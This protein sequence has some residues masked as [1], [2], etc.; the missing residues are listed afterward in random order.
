[1]K[2]V[3]TRMIEEA[4]RRE[5]SGCGAEHHPCARE[6]DIEQTRLGIVVRRGVEYSGE[7]PVRL[8]TGQA[9]RSPKNIREQ[10]VG[11]MKRVYTRMMEPS[12]ITITYQHSRFTFPRSLDL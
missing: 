5:V 9:A 12:V 10:R 1:M 6:S 11:R 3:Y 2:R 4:R 7:A 8:R